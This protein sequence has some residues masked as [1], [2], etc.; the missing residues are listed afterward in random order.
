MSGRRAKQ[1][2]RISGKDR[3]LYRI[4]KKVYNRGF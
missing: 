3:K 4:A 1:L 2:R